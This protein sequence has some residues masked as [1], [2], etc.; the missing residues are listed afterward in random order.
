MPRKTFVAVP[1]LHQGFENVFFHIGARVLLRTKYVQDS[2][3][4]VRI[5]QPGYD[6]QRMNAVI[7][8]F[9]VLRIAVLLTVP[10]MTVERLLQRRHLFGIGPGVGRM[11]E[12]FGRIAHPF[13]H[14]V[15]PRILQRQNVDIVAPIAPIPSAVAQQYGSFGA[16]FP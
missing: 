6:R 5:G 9:F 1:H 2:R 3:I 15:I 4:F 11:A 10:E 12:H 7:G 16:L 14:Q 13:D 8:R